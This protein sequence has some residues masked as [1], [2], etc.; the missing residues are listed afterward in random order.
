V[1]DPSG[2]TARQ[3]Y[4]APEIAQQQG[5]VIGWSGSTI[6]Y[7][8]ESFPPWPDGTWLVDDDGSNAHELTTIGRYATSLAF[9]PDQSR[10]LTSNNFGDDDGCDLAQPAL[11]EADGSNFWE[12]VPYYGLRNRGFGN[13]VGGDFAPGG[14]TAVL[15]EDGNAN[16]GCQA[17]WN[18]DIV[19]TDMSGD[20]VSLYEAPLNTPMS[21]PV[22]SPDGSQIMFSQGCDLWVMDADGANPHRVAS[23]CDLGV[24]SVDW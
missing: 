11:V 6:A 18:A 15:E 9:S 7:T 19:E 4:T 16:G 1:S 8:T 3:V 24:V 12:I 23:R 13:V 10:L 14:Q 22:Y 21:R 17:P 2:A 20:A 5:C